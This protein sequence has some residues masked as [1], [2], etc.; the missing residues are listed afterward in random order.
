[1]ALKSTHRPDGL[2]PNSGRNICW[3]V[4]RYLSD[5]QDYCSGP[6]SWFL[7]SGVFPDKQ[8]YGQCLYARIG[9]N[10]TAKKLSDSIPH[11]SQSGA[12]KTAIHLE[13]QKNCCINSLTWYTSNMK[14]INLCV[15]NMMINI[16]TYERWLGQK[17][18]LILCLKRDIY[19]DIAY[20]ASI[21]D[22]ACIHS[23]AKA[24]HPLIT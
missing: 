3:S 13:I 9:P 5:D 22:T 16:I 14:R 17:P 1:M 19:S 11:P 2:I 8:V 10:A 4:V 24:M 12:M 7:P 20:V 23:S 18:S 21:N 6:W 15:V